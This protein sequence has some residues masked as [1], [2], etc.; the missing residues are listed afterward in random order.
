MKNKRMIIGTITELPQFP[1]ILNE[2][3]TMLVQEIG[4][5]IIVLDGTN[6]ADSV[7]LL[8]IVIPDI[9]LL[10]LKLS[11]EEAIEVNRSYM[12]KSPEISLGIITDDPSAYYVSLCSTLG[13]HYAIEKPYDVESISAGVARQQLN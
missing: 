12:E 5:Y 7:S 4:D 10:N 13:S 3:E 11:R 6:Y 8:D 1:K 9:L 2:I